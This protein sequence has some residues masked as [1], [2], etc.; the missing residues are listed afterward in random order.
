MISDNTKA[1]AEMTPRL[2]SRIESFS[3]RFDETLLKTDDFSRANHRIILS[4]F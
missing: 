2:R 4:N 1:S 3:V